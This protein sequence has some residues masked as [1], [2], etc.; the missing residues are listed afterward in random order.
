MSPRAWILLAFAG[1]CT[2][3]APM[4]AA[5]HEAA[6]ARE[7]EIAQADRAQFDPNARELAVPVDCPKPEKPWPPSTELEDPPCWVRLEN[8][9]AHHLAE[10]RSHERI[11]KAHEAASAELMKR[12]EAACAGVPEDDRHISPFAHR[13]EIAGLT[14][15]TDASGPHIGLTYLFAAVQVL[16]E[17]RGGAQVVLRADSPA[18]V[19]EMVRRAQRLQKATEPPVSFRDPTGRIAP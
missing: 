8:P 12:E 6:A 10:A 15:D 14:I 9:T 4:S 13:E 3:V 16:D 18:A 2:S 7:R 19:D 5:E 1:G 11:A 17:G